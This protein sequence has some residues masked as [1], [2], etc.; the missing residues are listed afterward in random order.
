MADYLAVSLLRHG[1]TKENTRKA[2][3]GW[4]DSPLSEEGK[5]EL[6]PYIGCYS[7]PGIVFS[8]DLR[9]CRETAVILFPNQEITESAELRE[10]HFGDFEGK[11]YD[12]LQHLAAY[13]QWVEQPFTVRPVGGETYAEFC[14]RINVGFMHVRQRILAKGK[15]HAA[16]VTHGG[17]IRYLLTVFC[18]QNKS[19]FDWNIPYGG[20]YRLV[21]TKE[22]FRR[23]EKCMSLQEEPITENQPG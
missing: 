19:F 15:Q 7:R 16:L 12:E 20:G 22:S 1:M 6:Q 18:G 8:S 21:W 13:Q 2:Y 5:K 9:R 4:K 14:S 11:T 23:G 10:L 17:V 3:I